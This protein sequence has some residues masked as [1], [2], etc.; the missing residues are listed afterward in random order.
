MQA[1]NMKLNPAKC[2]FGVS[3][4]KFLGFMV[5]QRGIEVNSAKVK[6][7]L[8]TPIPNNKKELQ[9]LTGHL[10]ALGC[11]ISRFIDKLRPFFLT[12]KGAS[13]FDWTDKCEQ[14]FGIRDKEQRFVYYVSKAMAH[15]VTVLTNQPLRVTLHKPDLFG[16]ML[17]WAI[18]LNGASRV[19]GF[20]VGLI[21]QS[22]IGELME[23]AI[24]LN[25]FTSNNEAEYEACPSQ[26]IKRVPRKENVKADALAEIDVT[27]PIK[28]AVML[29]CKT[30]EANSGWMHDI[31]KY[32]QTGELPE[33]EKQAHRLR[34]QVARFTLINDQLYRRSFGGPYL[35]YLS[36]LEAKYVL[37][38]LHDGV[39]GN[40]PSG[41]T[42][43]HRA[44][45][46][47]YYWPTM[48]QD[49]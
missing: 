3:I 6:V 4:G 17:K 45:T 44:Y 38:E 15:Q 28:E 47:G 5:T 49:V 29:P 18:E 8:E 37:A 43:A 36:E 1:Y 23:L 42:L 2:A 7:V 22:P 35:K 13:T 21:L 41:L 24:P 16:R 11:F 48:K 39:C 31:V 30:N 20:E 10:I 12:L 25:F 27:L 9:C 33:D 32:L 26:V 14:A 34:I 40:Y 19:S 46:Q